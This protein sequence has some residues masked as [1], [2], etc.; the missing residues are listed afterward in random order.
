LALRFKFI[1]VEDCENAAMNLLLEND[2]TT[3]LRK[4]YIDPK[5]MPDAA[6]DL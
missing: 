5:E 1:G 3:S 2:L 4:M 6:Y